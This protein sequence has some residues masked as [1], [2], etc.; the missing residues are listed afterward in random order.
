MIL[1]FLVEG[2]RAVSSA[3]LLCL[4]W[5]RQRRIMAYNQYA[6]CSIL[7]SWLCMFVLFGAVFRPKMVTDPCAITAHPFVRPLRP[8]VFAHVWSF[9]Q[10][11]TQAYSN[12]QAP[13]SVPRIRRAQPGIRRTNHLWSNRICQ[14]LKTQASFDI[15]TAVPVLGFLS[16]E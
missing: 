10:S 2:S 6:P 11:L 8:Q 16:K 7:Y 15:W 13:L 12:A 5:A 3:L 9:N 14:T 1:C 4:L